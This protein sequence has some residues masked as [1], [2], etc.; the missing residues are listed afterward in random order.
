MI[1]ELI[2]TVFKLEVMLKEY[3]IE[4]Y[5]L[6]K[7]NKNDIDIFMSRLVLRNTN[8]VLITNTIDAMNMAVTERLLFN[9]FGSSTSSLADITKAMMDFRVKYKFIHM[10][11]NKKIYDMFNMK[12][13]HIQNLINM[14]I[15]TAIFEGGIDKELNGKIKF[16]EI[17]IDLR[18]KYPIIFNVKTK[19]DKDMCKAQ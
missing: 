8:I 7:Y 16:M 13:N 2:D 15:S 11:Q 19:H 6:N 18:K 14:K 9:S 10:S 1:M 3:G 17:I 12:L 4:K 5:F